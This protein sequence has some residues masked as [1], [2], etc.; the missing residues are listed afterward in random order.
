MN[1]K[2]LNLQYFN[3]GE[4]TIIM[5]PDLPSWISL[6]NEGYAILKALKK[7]SYDINKTSEETNISREDI[8]ELVMETENVLFN[9][10]NEKNLNDTL[11]ATVFLT[12][13]CNFSCSHCFY[14]CS[15]SKINRSILDFEKQFVP[16]IK[17]FANAGGKF[18]TFT[19]GEPLLT[20]V[21]QYIEE[22]NKYGIKTAILTNGSLITDDLCIMFKKNNVLIQ[23]SL[24]GD[25]NCFGDIRKN[26]NYYDVILGI[27]KL[28]KYKIPFDISFVPTK[29]NVDYFDSVLDVA[30]K[31]HATRFHIPLL[32]NHGNANNNIDSL[33]LSEEETIKFLDEVIDRYY[34]G[35]NTQIIFTFIDS[36]EK[37]LLYSSKKISCSLSKSFG[38]LYSNGKVF[39]CSEVLIDN[40]SLG[41]YEMG[42][43]IK[44]DIVEKIDNINVNDIN[45]CS[46]CC[47]KY[48]CG[49]GC[50][51]HSYLKYGTF[52]MEDSYCKVIKHCY[53]KILFKIA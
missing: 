6:D 41:K 36:I 53:E 44:N 4:K 43:Y 37:S 28:S 46:N 18:I 21:C 8:T 11:S 32:E 1:E 45:K 19:G 10:N 9:E 48:Y 31:Y 7:N 14:S 49:G 12:D 13:N 23:V 16:F 26:G 51:F 39:P 34:N 22:C 24:D 38:A 29:I 2:Y 50:R 30:I 35:L 27:E 33:M 52:Y 42:K 25:K 3:D 17:N 20:N 15:R 40:Y 47:F 5:N